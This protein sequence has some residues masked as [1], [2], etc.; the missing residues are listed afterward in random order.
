MKKHVRYRYLLVV[1]LL[2]LA[3][4][5]CDNLFGSSDDDNDTVIT[6]EDVEL[7]EE[8]YIDASTADPAHEIH[9]VLF[10]AS[11]DSDWGTST[12][13]TISSLTDTE[14]AG[15][16]NSYSAYPGAGVN[17]SAQF[18][19]LNP[20]GLTEPV[21]DFQEAVHIKSVTVANTTY[22]AL[23]MRDGDAFAKQFTTEDQDYFI[24]IFE[25]LDA[26]G[27]STGT[28]EF[29]LA[30]FQTDD[31]TGILDGWETVDLGALGSIKSLDVSFESSDVGIYGINTPLYVAIDDLKFS[32]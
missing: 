9:G 7:P 20:F 17:S 5:G 12:G 13:T 31:S 32:E 19:V 14:T 8:G 3:V 11:Y 27:V 18:A 22:A 23:S 15:Y 16:T 2:S 30:D 6:F 24:V 28:V 4:A 26:D 25:G 21:I 29:Y 1:V 10:T